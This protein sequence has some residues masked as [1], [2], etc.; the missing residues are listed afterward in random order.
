MCSWV[1][2]VERLLGIR[3]VVIDPRL[4]VQSL[5]DT[6]VNEGITIWLSRLD[7]VSAALLENWSQDRC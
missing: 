6:I 7:Q 5:I 2:S 4:T 1:F 3:A